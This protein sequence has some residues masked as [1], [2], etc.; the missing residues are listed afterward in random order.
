MF[1]FFSP[2]RVKSFLSV[3]LGNNAEYLL[4]KKR[5]ALHFALDNADRV[6]DRCMVFLVKGFCDRL[7]RKVC[8]LSYEIYRLMPCG[9]YF[10]VSL[11]AL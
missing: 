10:G 2:G 11:V 7:L 8:G 3:K 9:N 4:F 5:I 6:D 1:L